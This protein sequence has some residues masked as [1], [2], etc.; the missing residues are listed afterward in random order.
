MNL[1][2]LEILLIM[3]VDFAPIY[4]ETIQLD[5][6]NLPVLPGIGETVIL[7]GMA[8]EFYVEPLENWHRG[9]IGSAPDYKVVKRDF[10]L[11]T[12][13][14]CLYLEPVDPENAKPQIYIERSKEDK[15]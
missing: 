12:G 15:K 4:N 2:T 8:C 14:V 13:T 10:F 9:C 3:N 7:D 11:D 1:S 5:S 6:V